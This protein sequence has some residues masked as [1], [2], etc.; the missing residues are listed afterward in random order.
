MPWQFTFDDQ[1][2]SESSI[3]LEQMER[4]E[5]ITG[6]TWR[7][8]SIL[9]SAKFARVVAAVM[10]SDRTGKSFAEASAHLGQ[11]TLTEFLASVEVVEEDTPTQYTD[12]N[13]QPAGEP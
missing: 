3:T 7:N 9:G 13:P 5:D 4:I 2:Y 11:K 6:A 8:I 1:V 12:G 10:V